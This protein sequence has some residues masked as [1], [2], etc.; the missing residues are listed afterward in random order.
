M[1]LSNITKKIGV[2][3]FSILIAGLS[4]CEKKE[5]QVL[6]KRIRP[7]RYYTVIEQQGG[8]SIKF[9]G[10]AV[11]GKESS[12]SFKVSGTVSNIAVKVG[13]SVK[14]GDLLAELDKTD[15]NVDL[16]GA[17][18]SL[19]T[20]EADTQAAITRLNTTR[21]N[22]QRIEKLYESNNVSLSE[23]EQARGDYDTAKA[24]L[25]AAR[26]QVKTA[27]TRLQAAENQLRY[28]KIITP[29]K[30]V[31]NSINIE[32]NEEVSPGATVL[33]L[34][35]FS[36]LEVRIN[37]SDL[38]IARLQKGLE[39]DVYFSALP[40]RKFPGIVSE[41]PYAATGAPTYPVIIRVDTDDKA[42][43]PGMAAEVEFH[44]DTESS[45]KHIFLTPDSVG[46]DQSGN[47]VFALNEKEG[48]IAVATKR[49]VVLGE[50]TDK[51]FL[52]LQGVQKGDKIASSG[53]QILL[54]GMEVKLLSDPVND[55]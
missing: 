27:Q 4:G 53:L 1:T 42:L 29:Y 45:G 23:F 15:L 31:V 3:L 40:G 10:S 21:S 50:L 8:E 5:E 41:I 51:G 22:Y 36:D 55:W 35:G 18:A 49:K 19:K 30:G 9:S 52:V 14:K 20:A 6:E 37:L 16:E 44:F 48:G 25:G 43:R 47:F 17:R 13:D 33:T 28:T 32:E 26:S 38:Y 11:S 46:E 24:Q 2:V 39:C 34:S 7:V 12:L 54:E